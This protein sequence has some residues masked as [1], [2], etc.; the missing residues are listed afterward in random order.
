MKEAT[1]G[2]VL[3]TYWRAMRRQRGNA[4][5]IS[6]LVI[7][8]TA[9]EILQ[10]WYLK[11][12]F[13]L[14]EVHTPAEAALAIFLPVIFILLA[15]K[16]MVWVAWRLAGLLT[17]NFQTAVMYRLEEQAFSYTLGHS[18]QFFA[19]MFAGSL[20]KRITRLSRSF[21]TL[22]DEVE[23]RLLPV[24]VI[25]GVSTI[26]LYFQYPLLALIFCIWTILFLLINYYAS[27]WTSVAKVDEA[28]I[29]SEAGGAL[30]DAVSNAV[31]IKLFPASSYE[32]EKFD[33]VK[34][35]YMAAQ[36]RAW[37]RQEVVMALQA[38][39]MIGIEMGLMYVGVVFWLQ[40]IFSLGDLAFIQ[41]TLLLVFGKLW[42]IGRTFRHIFDSFAYAKE[43]VEIM[44]TPHEIKDQKGAKPLRIRKGEIVFRD[45]VFAFHKRPILN[46]LSLKIAPQEKVALVGP[47]GAG[48]STITKLLFRFYD[49]KRGKIL[50]DGQ[51]V[52]K[53]T[54][55][56]LREHISL[57]PQEPI[58]FHRTLMENIRYGRRDATDAEVIDAAKKARCHE[59][60][61]NLP[62]GYETFVGERG[63][64]L[65]GG[66]RQRV[67]IARA[68]LKNAPILVLDEATSSLDSES[69]SLIQDALHELMRDKTVIVIAHRL[70]TIM[71]MDRILVIEDGKLVSQGT[72]DELLR[73]KGTYQKLWNIQAGGFVSEE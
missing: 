43:M 16:G 35:R 48:K 63:I 54:Q 47:S 19:D 11:Q 55:D 14:L 4:F 41:T 70:S 38:L 26:G 21:E 42:D 25:L 40:G 59:F 27:R 64:K 53:A 15:C 52:S 49:I 45:V 33:E 5:F 23:F 2:D 44:Q 1:I 29:D 28:K 24:M 46:D 72:H 62:T 18:Y 37:R 58:L 69:E 73:R 39:L 32:T 30:A 22:A 17:I 68:I 66:E 61:S 9:A 7:L 3:R 31:T 20:V 51:D 10:P 8:G 57:V 12:L 56:S 6:L 36:R 60:I 67:A 34:R 65:S 13:D 50:I 71:Q